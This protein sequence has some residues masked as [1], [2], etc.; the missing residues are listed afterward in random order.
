M[1]NSGLF[2]PHPLSAAVLE[3]NV[4]GSGPGAYALGR[5]STDSTTF[6]ISYVGRSDSDLRGRLGA[7]V[8]SYPEFKYG[9]L[10]TAKDAF[11]KE[12]SLYHD[13]GETALDNEVHPA[14]PNGTS[15]TCPHCRAL[16]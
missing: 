9:F 2:G 13:F 6:I 11:L 10:P 14:R 15:W 12:C 8:G 4:K 3:L 1:A 5:T 7:W 16:G